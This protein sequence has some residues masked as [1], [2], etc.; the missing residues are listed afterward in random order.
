MKKFYLLIVLV[1]LLW[2]GESPAQENGYYS[3]P[4]WSLKTNALYWATTSPNLSLEIGLKPQWTLDILGSY[5]PWTFPD[6]Q[7]LKHWLVQPELRYWTCERFNGHFIGVHGHYAEYNIGGIKILGL[8]KYRYQGYL[9]GAGI[10]YGYQ[11]IIS[12]RLNLEATIGIGYAHL[13]YDQY[14]SPSCGR[15]IKEGHK[16]YFGPTKAGVSIIYFFK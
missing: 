15:F 9:W 13:N 11:W 6:N 1:T 12:N 7:K 14:D 2:P 5:N 16:N 4:A 8:K 10:S 3:L